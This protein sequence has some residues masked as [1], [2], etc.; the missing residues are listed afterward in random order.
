MH[1]HSESK[2][3]TS[4][5]K[6]AFESCRHT[7]TIKDLT[8]KIGESVL[9]ENVNATIHCGKTTA[10]IGPNGAGKSTLLSAIMGLIPYEGEIEFCQTT[11]HCVGVPNIGFV[12]QRIDFDRGM[13]ITVLDYLCLSQ[14]R[15]PLWLG[16]KKEVKEKSMRSLER[17]AADHLA[18]RALGKLSGGELQRVLLA[19]SL[20]NDPNI[21]LLDEPVSGVDMAGGELFCD[22]IEDLHKE[23]RFTL[24]LVSH[25]LSVV[26]S[27][28]DH[29]LC[30][31]R[32]VQCE[33]K[34][35]DVLTKETISDV[36]GLHVGLY[37]HKQCSDHHEE[38]S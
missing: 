35:V 16:V 20:M 31:N 29:V 7:I 1:V 28:A 33:G 15:R 24:V 14:Q 21:L 22:L 13:P 23:K 30:L 11:A 27:H 3:A 9:L 2:A 25:D 4:E 26:T 6:A 19:L 5:K 8:V 34:T 36:F 18:K 32:T 10:I 12:P 17:V 37:G 38:M